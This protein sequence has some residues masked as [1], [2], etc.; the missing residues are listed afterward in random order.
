MADRPSPESILDR[1]PFRDYRWL[2]PAEIIVSQW[3]RMKC[4]FGCPH[5]GRAA[6]CPPN[7]PSVEECRALFREYRRA[8]VLHFEHIAPEASERRAWSAHTNRDL[9]ALERDV[10]LAGYPMAFV[11]FMDSCHLCA[12]CVPHRAECKEPALSR[13]SP[14]SMAVDVFSTVHRIGYPIDVL[15]DLTAPMNRYAFLLIE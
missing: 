8:A 11:L 9:A 15:T 13:P 1:H 3:V 7:T 14:E 6:S 10:F 5:F 2:D 12:E 4:Q